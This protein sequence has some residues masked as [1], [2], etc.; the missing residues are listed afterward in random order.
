MA[1]PYFSFYLV[2][3]FL[4][5]P[6]FQCFCAFAEENQD[7]KNGALVSAVKIEGLGRTKE[8]YM[9]SVLGKYAGIPESRIDLHEVKVT[10]EELELFSETEV[11]LKKDENGA[12]VLFI[13]VK[14]KWSFIP[15]PFFMYS[16][17][18][19]FMGGAFVMDTNAFGIRDNYVVGGVFSKNIQL[20]LMAYSRPTRDIRH[21]G[22]TVGASFNHRDNEEKNLSGEKIFEY[23]AMGG[24]VYAAVS[25]KITAHSK[26]NAGLRY[27]YT[28]AGVK[29][30]YT[31]YKEKVK[32][33]H[34]ITPGVG[35]DVSFSSL[36]EW[37]LSVKSFSIDGAVTVL[38][39]GS[40]AESLGFKFTIQYPLPVTR[41]RV[42]TQYALYLSNNLPVPLR[43]TQMVVGT[44]I[45]PDKFHGT[46]MGGADFG[47]E[48]GILNT[49]FVMFSAYGL[50][51]QFAGEDS[52]GSFVMNFGYSTGL[53]MYLKKLA[54]P[55][56]AVG[57]SHNL[58][59][60]EIKFSATIGMGGF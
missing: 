16:S 58:M 15:V 50:L 29:K 12:S 60:N 31:E 6:L 26:I 51:E 5:I 4:F 2:F 20:A 34:A 43:P 47:L 9:L 46:K 17:S 35:W 55:A 19:G 13:K 25:D 22:F 38:A 23:N 21:P 1:K 54:I 36:N 10:L 45:M 49:K 11:S 42:L 53:K 37:F 44:T 24:S 27:S 56:I 48:V 39:S 57:V 41:L 14:E 33:F 30:K 40:C 8:S 28:N 7:V 52:D 32:S 3:F 59:Q 18:T